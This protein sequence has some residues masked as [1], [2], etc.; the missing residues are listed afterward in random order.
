VPVG[1]VWTLAVRARFPLATSSRPRVL[2]SG[3]FQQD[4]VVVDETGMLGT[5]PGEFLSCGY[6]VGELR[7]WH[8][9]VAVGRVSS[10]EFY[11]DGKPVGVAKVVCGERMKAIGNTAAGGRPWSGPISSVMVWMRALTRGEVAE[12]HTARAS[13]GPAVLPE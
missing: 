12:L 13:D 6:A 7:G 8:E 10:T 2:A 1:R 5:A 9:I 11:V 4:H 3:G